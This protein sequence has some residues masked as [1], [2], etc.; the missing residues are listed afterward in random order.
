VEVTD[1]YVFVGFTES[2]DGDFADAGHRGNRD[3]AVCKLDKLGNKLWV[4]LYG[5]TGSESG[6]AIL[7]TP[8]G[9]MVV[10]N[11]NSQVSGHVTHS[12]GLK[13]VWVL[14]LDMEGSLLWQKSYGGSGEESTYFHSIAAVD[15]SSFI[16]N[17][18]SNSTG[19][20]NFAGVNKGSDDCWLFKISSDGT[21]L[22]QK[23]Y[24]G[25]ASEGAGTIFKV[26]D[27]F[28]FSANSFSKDGDLTANKGSLDAWVVKINSSGSIVWQKSFG[29]SDVDHLRIFDVSTSGE[30]FLTG[31]SFSRSGKT[32]D[33]PGNKGGSDLWVLKL[34]A[35]G[36]KLSSH[37]L[38]SSRD[39]SGEWV[40]PI[41]SNQFV[42]V[43]KCG[44]NDGDVTGNHGLLD[45]W[46]VRYQL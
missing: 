8:D 17:A 38:G 23:N 22:W 21:L 13:D 4:K 44:A 37:T 3:L 34:D 10:G 9:F 46:M 42:S 32:S 7:K 2:N 18:K 28:V 6:D 25:S 41:G 33:L 24:G 29:G 14:K 26:A 35:S 40:L 31:Y 15:G 5:G 27:G 36:N 11:T 45:V 20:G 19:G 43:G 1:G 16:I 39:D 12:Y 30:I